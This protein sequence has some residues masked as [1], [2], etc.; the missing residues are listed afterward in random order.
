MNEKLTLKTV[1][2]KLGVSR[3]TMSN[4]YNRPD[5]LSP[6]LR[7]RIINGAAA[8]GYQGPNPA[9]RLL[10]TGKTE[11]IGMIFYDR[12][13]Q[14][15]YDE[16]AIELMKGVTEVCE[17]A[18]VSLLLVPTKKT[19][20][21]SVGCLQALADGFIVYSAFIDNN[22]NPVSSVLTRALPTVGIDQRLV[23]A[24]MVGIDDY[25][26]GYK[27]ARHVLGLGHRKLAIIGFY[28]HRDDT[29]G[30]AS[31]ERIQASGLP[32]SC[33]RLRGYRAALSEWGIAAE[34]VAYV[35]TRQSTEEQGYLAARALLSGPDRPSAVLCMCDVFALGVIRAANEMQLKVP[36]DLSVIGFDG[37]ASGQK[38]PNPLTTIRQDGRAKGAFAAKMILGHQPL[39]DIILPV[40]LVP[41]GT[42]GSK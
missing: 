39:G 10:R 22:H 40:E 32:T 8:L 29:T 1:A 4:A 7:E 17:S 25:D 35:E 13:S 26:G 36:E 34:T 33:N 21:E 12:T 9:G 30:V 6:A 14:V 42:C 31:E 15:F 37:I 23:N 5:Q 19:R 16:M 28:L 38:I 3:T 27:A 18:G 24:P 2:E 41:G 11:T 20:R